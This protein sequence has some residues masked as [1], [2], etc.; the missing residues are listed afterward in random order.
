MSARFAA[1]RS[2]ATCAVE[3]A[4]PAATSRAVS[5]ASAG[6]SAWRISAASDGSVAAGGRGAT[7]GM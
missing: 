2:Q 5:A 1:S 3:T 6:A 7:G 4:R